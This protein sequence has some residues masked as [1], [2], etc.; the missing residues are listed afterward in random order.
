[1]KKSVRLILLVSSIVL[2]AIL[3]SAATCTVGPVGPVTLTITVNNAQ[4]YGLSVQLVDD[5]WGFPT[6][7]H[8]GQ[9]LSFQVDSGSR[10]RI[11]NGWGYM[12][13]Q[14]GLTYYDVF[15]NM[16]FIIPGGG[17]WISPEK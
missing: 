4:G 10:M 17:V 6:W 15:S 11:W 12:Q 9:I 13:F 8:P 16:S 7:V 5:G 1:M 2:I 3:F 14:S